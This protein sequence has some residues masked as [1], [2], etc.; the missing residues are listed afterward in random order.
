MRSMWKGSISFGL[1]NIPVKMYTATQEKQ[2]RFN[3]LHSLCHT[4]IK[5]DK[6][7]PRCERSVE[8]EEI[9]R[10]Y[11][12]EKGRYVVF[13][14]EEL[15]SF[16]QRSTGTVD[17]LRFVDLHEIDPVYFNKT[18]YLEPS[19]T[20]GKAYVLLKEALSSSGR[21]AVARITIRSKSSLAVIRIY[22]N[23]LALETIFYP[24]EIRPADRLHIAVPGPIDERELTMAISLID[25][26]TEPFQ[27]EHYSDER[28]EEMLSLIE[29]KI[30]GREFAVIRPGAEKEP[31]VDLLA[32]LEAS[33]QEASLHE[34][35][36]R[37]TSLRAPKKGLE[38]FS[39]GMRH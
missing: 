30:E 8:T 39:D 15:E 5:Y 16:S 17:I 29:S 18:Y 20:G 14:D 24:D 3:Q 28:R 12:Y 4:P 31:A 6:V 23:I 21:I 32:A 11:E 34:A 35:S 7:C 26:L 2:V 19:E 9:V 25:S 1:V 38:D 10:G 33:L 13:S 27:P 22:H 36:L 37:E